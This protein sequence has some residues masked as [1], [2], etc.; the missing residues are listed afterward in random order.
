MS[1]NYVVLHCVAF[2]CC[3]PI[4]MNLDINRATAT[5]NSSRICTASSSELRLASLDARMSGLGRCLAC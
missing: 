4:R 5:R 1:L 2:C 3:G